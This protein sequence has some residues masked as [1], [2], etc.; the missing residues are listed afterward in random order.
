MEEKELTSHNKQL[1]RWIWLGCLLVVIAASLHSS[2]RKVGG[3][4]TWVAMA[5]GR[6]QL[7]PW[8]AKQSD[9]TWQM[10]ILDKFGIHIT[11]Q[12]P[13]SAK[14]RPYK[15]ESRSLSSLW[16]RLWG[17][18]RNSKDYNPSFDDV[19][20]VNQNWLTHVLFY[21]MKTFW[22]EQG[23]GALKGEILIVFYKFLQAI[24]T[25]LFAYWAG[26]AMGAHPLLAGAA[27]SFGMLLSRSYIDLRPNVSTILF[28]AIM[29]YLLSMWKKGYIR[30]LFWMIPVTIIWSNVHGGFIYAIMIFV[31]VAGAHLIQNYLKKAAYIFLLGAFAIW[32][33]LLIK[34]AI[35][36]DDGNDV[37]KIAGFLAG[38]TLLGISLLT[39]IK[40]EVITG[41]SFVRV[42]NKKILYLLWGAFIV[43]VIPGIFS[44]FG[45]ENLI[46]PL[47]IIIGNEGDI[48][49]NVI[50]W[51][52]IWNKSGFGNAGPY[53]IFLVLLALTFISW[54]ILYLRKPVFQGLHKKRQRRVKSEGPWP[55]IDLAHLVIMAITVA[56]SIKSR[57]FIF[58]GGVVLA[59]FLASMLQDIIDMI[60][61]LRAQKAGKA[62]E[63]VPMSRPQAF[64]GAGV[65]VIAVLIISTVFILAMWDTYY[66]PTLLGEDY[67][68][69]RRMVGIQDQPVRAM[70]F[71]DR[72]KI[73][74]VV[75]N[76]WTNGGYVAFGQQPNAENGAPSS[77]VYID[78]RAQAA[79]NVDHFTHWQKLRIS[80]PK[81]NPASYKMFNQILKKYK[82][83]SKDPDLY[84]K[85]I[86][87]SL[88]DRDLYKN[89]ILLARNGI[90]ELDLTFRRMKLK[91]LIQ[92]FKLKSDDPQL[93]DKIID[94]TRN[95]PNP[96]MFAGLVAYSASEPK[97]YNRILEKEGISI[98]LL[99]LTKPTVQLIIRTLQMAGNWLPVFVDD[100]NILLLNSKNR[101]HLKLF[102]EFMEEKLLYPDDFSKNFSLGY[103]FCQTNNPVNK[104]RGLQCLMKIK[105]ERYIP[106]VYSLIFQTGRALQKSD[107][108]ISYFSQQRKFHKELIDSG[109]RLRGLEHC[110]ALR[111]ICRKLK[112]LQK[113]D[114]YDDEMRHY[115]ILQG[116][117]KQDYEEGL[118]W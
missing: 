99:S 78:G 1:S 26:R 30:A 72:N 49:R 22:G 4:D 95:H 51:K 63:L 67:T 70:K 117:L 107:E 59:P 45:W 116:K 25:G 114:K 34:G 52:P 118:F 13:F 17:S 96:K 83:S 33:Y 58:L 42:G 29:I 92:S 9:R 6:Y 108:L 77:K 43:T 88:K 56:M 84:D 38:V 10:R 35:G 105:T 82:L 55:Q 64:L 47:I 71:M 31:F 98:V 106:R 46:H 23:P 103:Y 3:G 39:L 113:T 8:A 28:A 101:N 111:D 50:E 21:K 91:Q 18:F 40:Y 61:I 27:V 102:K 97:L 2:N 53:I 44:P 20:W 16:N 66:R 32:A 80:M 19:G 24:L 36:L 85:L 54:W 69:F 87:K 74:G 15:P 110:S 89:L 41:E 73:K 104:A 14:S 75:F 57:R 60:R 5:C 93:Y 68:V 48:W 37:W 94:Q 109:Q 79:Y 11:Q 86:K 62:L 81:P 115:E 100:R 65:S 76:E 90:S 12:D 112:Q 7:G